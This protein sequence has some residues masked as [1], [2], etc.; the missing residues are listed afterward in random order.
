MRHGVVL[1][2]KI[3]S[4]PSVYPV[5]AMLVI[6]MV[7]LQ[8]FGLTVGESSIGLAALI[9]WV[10]LGW[11]IYRSEIEVSPVRLLLLGLV[12]GAMALSLI[13]GRNQTPKLQAAGIVL[14]LYAALVFRIPASLETASRCF[15]VFQSSMIII[16][17]IVICQQVVQ[18]TIGNKYWPNINNIVPKEFLYSG[19][20]YL[21]PY[22]W[23]SPYF[24]PNGIFFLEPSAVSFFLAIAIGLEIAW[25]R[26]LRRLGLYTMAMLACLA[27]TGPLSLLLSAPVWT[28]KLGRKFV[29]ALMLLGTPMVVAAIGTGWLDG[30]LAR[31][32]EMSHKDSSAYERIVVPFNSIA[33]QL[34]DPEILTGAGPGTSSRRLNVVQWPFSKL[35]YEYGLLTAVLFHLFLLTC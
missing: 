11:L 26:N 10:G 35:F 5:Y 8:K 16:A 14:V 3:I 2:M 1:P 19:F 6:S 17:I 27:A 18:Y 25:F 33:N 12:F 30:V 7:F 28:F 9:I 21:R 15:Q 32:S 31:S 22:S 4:A 23:Q 13:V 24:E 34:Q 29:F 20:M